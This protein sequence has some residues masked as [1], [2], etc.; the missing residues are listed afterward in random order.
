METIQPSERQQAVLEAVCAG[1]TN[2]EIARIEHIEPDT[3]K[4]HIGKLKT[5]LNAA[6][7]SA[8]ACIAGATQKVD[9]AKVKALA[10][11][12]KIHPLVLSAVLFG[13]AQESFW[14]VS[15]DE[16]QK[17]TNPY[18]MQITKTSPKHF[19]CLGLKVSFT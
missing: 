17:K 15:L 14:W 3:V 4:Y 19:R 16:D 12:K 13:M 8:L 2:K 5:I 1:Y 9:L 18:R 10:D 11:L 7:R 6:N